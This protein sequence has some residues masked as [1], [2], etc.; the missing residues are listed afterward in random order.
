LGLTD[1]I[2]HSYGSG[3]NVVN[4]NGG[5]VDTTD[6]YTKLMIAMA[7]A[8]PATATTNDQSGEWLPLGTFAMVREGGD[9][10]PSQTLQLALDRN[11]TISGVLFNLPEDTSTPVHGTLDRA[12]QR[13]V[14]DLGAKSDQVAE[15]NIYELTKDEATLVVH[16]GN[17]KPQT[18]TLV[19][20][21]TPPTD[22]NKNDGAPSQK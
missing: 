17:E 16:K 11:G 4:V 21:R 20:F 13:V 10:K 7:N 22:T 1:A 15:A 8:S 6:A 3:G 2:Y 19:H 18:Y 14:F 5:L 9:D 12:T